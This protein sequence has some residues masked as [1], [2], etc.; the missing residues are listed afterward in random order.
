L[1]ILKYIS[2][3]YLCSFFLLC[4]FI[5]WKSKHQLRRRCYI[6]YIPVAWS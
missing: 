3:S 6:W 4:S 2:G 1:K 5:S